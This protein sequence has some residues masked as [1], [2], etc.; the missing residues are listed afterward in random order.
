[1]L[2]C[3]SDCEEIEYRLNSDK[4]GSDDRAYSVGESFYG[5]PS[6]AR[7]ELTSMIRDMSIDLRKDHASVSV[8]RNVKRDAPLA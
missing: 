2:T 7:P 8:P 1:V 4:T 5:K 3:I 6:I